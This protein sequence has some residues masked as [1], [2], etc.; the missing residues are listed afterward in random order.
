MSN[1]ASIE[2][3]KEDFDS[4]IT[5]LEHNWKGIEDYQ[6]RQFC[7]QLLDYYDRTEKLSDK[8]ISYLVKYMKELQE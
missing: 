1:Y 3:F 7:R 6:D 8:Q 5:F 2:S 4:N